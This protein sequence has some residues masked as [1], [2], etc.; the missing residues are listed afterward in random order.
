LGWTATQK[1]ALDD[2]ALWQIPARGGYAGGVTT[3]SAAALGYLKYLR[4]N[5]DD[6]SLLQNIAM[7][8]LSGRSVELGKDASE[9]RRGQAVGFFSM[10]DAVLKQCVAEL[11]SLDGR[12]FESLVAEINRGLENTKADD[13]ARQAAYVARARQE[14]K[15][16]RAGATVP[17]PVAQPH[18][19]AQRPVLRLV[20]DND[21]GVRF[22]NALEP[23]CTP[24]EV[25]HA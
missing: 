16:R 20:V 25:I 22:I 15:A 3:G 21:P 10:I 6:G 9:S 23:I 12:S 8:M 18:Q 13:K 4:T 2:R 11:D 17:A 7:N 24:G 5:P 14:A 19:P 1:K